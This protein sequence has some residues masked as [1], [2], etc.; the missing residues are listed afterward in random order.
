MGKLEIP[1][2]CYNW[3]ALSSLGPHQHRHPGP[4]RSPRHRPSGWSRRRRLPKVVEAGQVSADSLWEALGYFLDAVV[5]EAEAAGV[6][7][8]L[9]PDDPPLPV[10]RGRPAD[11]EFAGLVPPA[12]EP[13]AV[14]IGTPITVLPG[15]LRIDD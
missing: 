14:G 2:L 9:H 13:L 8:A 4:W 10:V 6:R 7:L 5:P 11:H 15:Q 3:M 1:V 12:V